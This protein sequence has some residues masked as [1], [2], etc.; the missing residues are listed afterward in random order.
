MVWVS[1]AHAAVPKC[2]VGAGTPVVDYVQDGTV[3]LD[4]T[5][6]ISNCAKA[7][8]SNEYTLDATLQQKVGGVWTDI[9]HATATRACNT[10]YR[11]ACGT[12]VH[13]Y[14]SLYCPDSDSAAKLT[15]RVIAKELTTGVTKTGVAYT[16][17]CHEWGGGD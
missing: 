14:P 13:F 7:N 16:A 6:S 5:A 4:A 8:P 11:F 2:T 10:S 12:A 1:P 17:T 15:V 9:D 3:V